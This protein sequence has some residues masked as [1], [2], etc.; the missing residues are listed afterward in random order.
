MGKI[1]RTRLN[2][3]NITKTAISKQTKKNGSDMKEVTAKNTAEGTIFCNFLDV[4]TVIDGYSIGKL[5]RRTRDEY[6]W[7][8]RWRR[9]P[10]QWEG[11]GGMNERRRE[12]NV[13]QYMRVT[14]RVFLALPCR[15]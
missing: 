12:E 6:R 4:A 13:G 3:T 11:A 1:S 9:S 15:K 5:G 7:L 14:A 10:C 2:I 8:S